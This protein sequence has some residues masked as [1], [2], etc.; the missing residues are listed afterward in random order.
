ML[1]DRVE[2]RNFVPDSYFHI[3]IFIPF[4]LYSNFLYTSEEFDLEK[5]F[6][7][8][9]KL[10]DLKDEK[11]KLKTTIVKNFAVKLGLNKFT[12]NKEEWKKFYAIYLL[13]FAGSDFIWPQLPD[14]NE[15][16][17]IFD[18]DIDPY[19]EPIGSELAV[20]ALEYRRLL[21]FS[22]LDQSRE[23]ICINRS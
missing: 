17:L 7:G 4:L 1:T 3:W 20:N 5:K 11:Q 8:L 13:N 6:A 15:H 12:K 16:H 23:Y 18:Y 14:I 19:W 9:K 21:D 22:S 10:S 2:I